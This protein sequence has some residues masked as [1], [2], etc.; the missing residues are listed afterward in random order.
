MPDLGLQ[1]KL[2][3]Q[4]AQREEDGERSTPNARFLGFSKA[5]KRPG[6]EARGWRCLL[7]G[8]PHF[9]F[10]PYPNCFNAGKCVPGSDKVFLSPSRWKGSYP[11]N[12]DPSP[13]LLRGANN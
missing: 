10:H 3:L 5:L 8:V 2:A 9:G 11:S 7:P 1:G 4:P 6:S 12:Q 13:W